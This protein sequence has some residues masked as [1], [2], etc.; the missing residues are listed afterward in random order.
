MYRTISALA[1][2]GVFISCWGCGASADKPVNA[3]VA[4][5]SA[6]ARTFTLDPRQQSAL[7]AAEQETN[8]GQGLHIDDAIIK[9]C[10]SVTPPH[11]GFDSAKVKTDYSNAF[12]AIAECM[13][14]G[15]LNGRSLLL[16]GHADRRG[17]DDYNLALG[18]RRAESVRGAIESFGVERS[19]LDISSKGEADAKGTDEK[20]YAEDRRVDIR[21]KEK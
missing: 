12:G 13:K 8:G 21:L 16:V 7:S 2:L 17:E 10:P 18:G 14:T 1:V 11:F 20:G 3:P 6:S 5:P 4:S 9:L 19:R 15:G